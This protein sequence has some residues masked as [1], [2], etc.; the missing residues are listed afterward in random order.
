[1]KMRSVLCCAILFSLCIFVSTSSGQEVRLVTDNWIPYY[2]KNLENQGYFSAI[3][4]EAFEKAGHKSI[5]SFMPW[6]RAEEIARNGS[7]DALLGAYHTTE[8]EK[9]FVFSTPIDSATMN[10]IRLKS[11]NITFSGDLHDLENLTIGIVR[12]YQVSEEF[13]SADYLITEGTTTLTQSIKKLLMGRVDIL[14][15]SPVVVKDLMNK[16]FSQ[17]DRDALVFLESHPVVNN[18]LFLCFSKKMPNVETVVKDFN[19]ALAE[20]KNNGEIN[21]IKKK[22]GF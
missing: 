4:K 13:N 2:G 12:G 7:E 6:K 5:I 10:V 16:E 8:R 1:M 20:M 11:S 3:V 22:Y 15:E 17:A 19:T 18:A 14:I 21:A 9:Y